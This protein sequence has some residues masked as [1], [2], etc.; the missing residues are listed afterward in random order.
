[1]KKEYTKEERHLYFKNLREEWKVNKELADK[2]TNA[3]ARFNAILNEAGGKISYHSYYFTLR[4]MIACGYEGEP[5]IDCKTYQGWLD[6][7]F[8]VKKD[9]KSKINGVVWK[10][11]K[12]KNGEEGDVVY[13]KVYHLFHKTQVEE[14]VK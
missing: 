11:F 4:S 14:L 8:Q 10:A 1:M 12:D 13:P 6:R 2:D 7:G 3:Q 9:E 5:Y